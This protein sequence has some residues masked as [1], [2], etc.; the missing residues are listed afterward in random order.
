MKKK[1][2]KVKKKQNEKK[3]SATKNVLVFEDRGYEDLLS[4]NN[5]ENIEFF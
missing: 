4:G 3:Y 5:I 1:K 2:R